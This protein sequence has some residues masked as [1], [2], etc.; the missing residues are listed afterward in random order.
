ML[1]LPIESDSVMLKVLKTSR[2]AQNLKHARSNALPLRTTHDP[3]MYH[4]C[5]ILQ[6]QSAC[7]L[8]PPAAAARRRVHE[9]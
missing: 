9:C 5:F 4:T 6:H 3:Y 2:K 1:A 8:L 7:K